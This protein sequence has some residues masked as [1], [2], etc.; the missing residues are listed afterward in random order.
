MFHQPCHPRMCVSF[1][2]A[3]WTPKIWVLPPQ[4][5]SYA[6]SPQPY[7]RILGLWTEILKCMPWLCG[8]KQIL[9]FVSLGLVSQTTTKKQ[10][11]GCASFSYQGIKCTGSVYLGF[12]FLHPGFPEKI[13]GFLSLDI[14]VCFPR[15]QGTKL[16]RNVMSYGLVNLKT[17]KHHSPHPWRPKQTLDFVDLCLVFE[18]KYQDWVS[19]APKASKVQ[20]LYPLA[21]LTEPTKI[22]CLV[23]L[24]LRTQTYFGFCF[25]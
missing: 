8:L 10:K 5:N 25:P 7:D 18:E 22:M 17:Y 15:P 13:L 12:I 21:L 14:G 6:I 23:Q 3:S 16:Y 1:P 4:P 9:G 20:S 19:W 24:L 11:I 2:L